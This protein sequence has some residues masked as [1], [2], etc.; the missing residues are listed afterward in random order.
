MVL[1]TVA[2]ETF[3]FLAISRIVID[4]TPW[5]HEKGI[6]GNYVTN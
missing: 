2:T 3:A 6:A 1:E 5:I 4:F